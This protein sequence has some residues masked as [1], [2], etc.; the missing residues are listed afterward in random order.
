[1]QM[2]PKKEENEDDQT[3]EPLTRDGF[4]AL[5]LSDPLDQLYTRVWECSVNLFDYWISK[6]KGKTYSLAET[7]SCLD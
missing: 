6:L 3:D 4:K 5:N 1:M 2:V 7:G